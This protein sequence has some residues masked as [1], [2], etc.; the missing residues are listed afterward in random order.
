[1]VST[2]SM[3]TTISCRKKQAWTAV[4]HRTHHES[5]TDAH[6]YHC[7]GDRIA[8][9]VRDWPYRGVSKSP[10]LLLTFHAVRMLV[11][12]KYFLEARRSS[13]L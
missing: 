5:E 11:T 6:G 3:R 12:H 2:S 7:R 9:F 13:H 8:C 1:M 10:C 4:S